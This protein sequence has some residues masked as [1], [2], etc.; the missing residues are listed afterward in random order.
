MIY[1]VCYIVGFYCFNILLRDIIKNN[2]IKK[3]SVF[4]F[5][6]FI[7]LLVMVFI[8]FLYRILYKFIWG[9]IC[10]FFRWVKVSFIYKIREFLFL[11]WLL[12]NLK[13]SLW[14]NRIFYM[15]IF[16]LFNCVLFFSVLV[17]RCFF[18]FDFY[19]ELFFK[20]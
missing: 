19:I 8:N 11:L 15:G 20:K 3:V 7:E 16:G 10:C 1:F 17:L 12:E 6:N 2:F 14:F 18:Y 13:L 5:R 4:V 9:K